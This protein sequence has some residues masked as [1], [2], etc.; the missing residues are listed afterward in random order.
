M[1]PEEKKEKVF[2]FLP[3]CLFF[4]F[5]SS[6][7]A[8]GELFAWQGEG[9]FQEWKAIAASDQKSPR[10]LR[11]RDG[12]GKIYGGFPTDRFLNVKQLLKLFSGGEK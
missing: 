3:A 1:R 11:C 6:A 7:G 10:R 12:G 4:T 5:D 2:L 9:I 8:S